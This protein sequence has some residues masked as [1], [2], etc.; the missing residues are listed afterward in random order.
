MQSQIPGGENCSHTINELSNNP[1]NGPKLFEIVA[2]ALVFQ[3]VPPVRE[4]QT[5]ERV[6]SNSDKFNCWLGQILQRDI[7]SVPVELCEVEQYGIAI[8]ICCLESPDPPPS[9]EDIENVEACLEQQI[10]RFL[11]ATRVTRPIAVHRLLAGQ[12]FIYS[13]ST[14]LINYELKLK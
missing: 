6:S 5:S 13:L 8:R 14:Y 9:F 7:E 12:V 10:V 1:I 11:L 4:N 2:S 3:Y